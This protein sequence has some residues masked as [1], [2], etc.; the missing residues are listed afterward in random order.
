MNQALNNKFPALT[1]MALA[2]GMLGYGAV[3]QANDNTMPEVRVEAART[4][5]Q[6]N[7]TLVE[8]AELEKK[9][10]RD[11]RDIF[12]ADPG[13]AVGGGG[14]TVTQKIY[15]RG[16]EETMLNVTLDGAQQNGYLF[17]H[18]ARNVI[19]PQL[20]KAVEVQKGAGDA[21][22]G[23]G[24]LGGAIRMT[25]KDAGDLLRKGE[26]AGVMVGGSVSSNDSLG[27]SV[28]VYGK[29]DNVMD[30]LASASHKEIDDYQDGNGKTVAHSASKQDNAL[31]K[32]G[33]NVSETQRLSFSYIGVKDEGDRYLRPH[34]YAFSAANTTPL[35]TEYTRDTFSLNWASKA[36]GAQPAIDL[37]AYQDDN[38]YLRTAGTRTYGEAALTLG[39]DAKL[40]SRFGNNKLEY[41][42]NHSK[43]TSSV[44][45]GTKTGTIDSTGYRN[46]GKETGTVS[47]VFLQNALALGTDWMFGLGARY[48]RYGY[49]DTH[50]QDIDS[51]G[52]SPNASITYAPNE[53]SST[54][55]AWANVLR[56]VRPIEAYLIDVGPGPAVYLTDKNIKAE[57]A[58]TVDLSTEYRA[59]DWS[60]KASV[61]QT[62]IAN[63][64]GIYYN[65]ALPVATRATRKNLG[66]AESR[67]FEFAGDRQWGDV[68]V[69]AAVAQSKSKLEGRDLSDG[70]MGLGTNTG[71][72]WKLGFDYVLKPFN[73]ELGWASRFV[74][75]LDTTAADNNAVA[76]TKQGYGVHDLNVNW[77]PTGKD[78][79]KVRFAVKNVFDKYYYDQSTYSFNSANNAYLG[80][81]EP[82]RDYRLELSYKF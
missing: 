18:Q 45:N 28:T 67:G 50:S 3:A 24:A 34:M 64:V 81:A 61:F 27:A 2:I 70:D 17:H 9:Q 60:V 6:P 41:G 40:T 52:I 53:A 33:W 62:T 75:A 22:N 42:V 37:N 5:V 32:M 23:P 12:A 63:Y 43:Q 15:V 58:Q 19:D 55:L 7:A 30:I 14:G 36:E 56:G 1:V 78:T 49:T 4:P 68:K 13:V 65:A 51:N 46:A 31:V 57:K 16:L 48:D 73:L 39:V 59:K 47:G 74:E 54:R 77:Q 76:Y 72:T 21:T 11:L 66:E 44:I 26:T 29:P 80:L 69:S 82:G 71:R 10:A 8:S 25:T 20:L 38:Q 35:L 79:L